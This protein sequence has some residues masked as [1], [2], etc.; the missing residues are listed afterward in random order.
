MSES[1]FSYTEASDFLKR[2]STDQKNASVGEIITESMDFILH[3]SK[4]K[5]KVSIP[6]DLWKTEVDK[7]QI[8]QVI[9]NLILNSMEAM[10]NGGVISV[11]CR[12]VYL[13]KDKYI[14][15]NIRD[16][17]PG[18]PK[19]NLDRIFDP[20]FST[21]NRKRARTGGNIFHNSEA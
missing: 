3:G 11:N 19:E 12:N 17:G 13:G 7:E 14:Q 5:T 2:R 18:I 20:Y 16:N 8:S 15:I 21:K 4:I 1:R 10:P 9:Q 6:A